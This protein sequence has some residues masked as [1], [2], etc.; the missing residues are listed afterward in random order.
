[1]PDRAVYAIG[2]VGSIHRS[3]AAHGLS[4][5]SS[6]RSSSPSGPRADAPPA[7]CWRSTARDGRLRDL[8][9]RRLAALLAPRRS[10]GVQR[11]AG[12]AGARPRHQGQRRTDRVP[13]RA[14][15]DGRARRWC[16]P[17]P[18]RR[19]KPGAAGQAAGRP[20]A[21]MLG[22]RRGSVPAASS[23]CDVLRVLRGARRDAAAA[24]H[25]AR[26][27]TPPI[28]SAIRPCLRAHRAPWRRRPR[29]CISTRS[30]SR[31][32]RARG[33]RHAFVTLHV[34]AG[35][36]Q[37]VRVDD[38]DAHVMHAEYARGAAAH[39]RC[40]RRGARR[41][42]PRGRRRHDRGAQPG[43]ARRG[44]RAALR[45]RIEGATRM[46]IKPGLPLSRGRRA[47]S[48]IFTCPSR[49]C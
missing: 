8:Q 18:A 14:G 34:G 49:R 32:S 21:R 10:A 29:G 31:R 30:C 11:H 39:L 16:T 40:D 22:A 28:A 45:A 5:R 42:R 2:A 35:T 43:D 26:P 13:A 47:C 9:F 19:C 41:R 20:R 37:P 25:R 17:A 44:R 6:R 7:G 4:F 36:F 46:F 38:I 27:P 24:L 3:D 15:A 48:P 12:D 1:M 33:V 23:R